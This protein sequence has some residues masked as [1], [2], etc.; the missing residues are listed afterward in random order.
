MCISFY[1]TAQFHHLIQLEFE[2]R[3]YIEN[4]TNLKSKLNPWRIQRL[5]SNILHSKGKYRV[6]QTFLNNT[7]SHLELITTPKTANATQKTHSDCSIEL[8]CLM[9]I[10]SERHLLF[11][12][13]ISKSS[14]ISAQNSHDDDCDALNI[15]LSFEFLIIS[16]PK[17]C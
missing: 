10:P 16:I 7:F 15:C 3:Q 1:S 6:K 11:A 13:Q 2:Q 14:R 9:K 12:I 17:Y 8:I 4:W 5:L